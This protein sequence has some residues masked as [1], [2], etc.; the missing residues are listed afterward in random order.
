MTLK[1]S[2]SIWLIAIIVV[3]AIFAVYLPS[4]LLLP[5][6]SSSSPGCNSTTINHV[7]NPDRLTVH[8]SCQTVTGTVERIL[9]EVDGDT[10]IRLRV[11]SQYQG[12]LND[13]NYQHQAGTL[14]LEIVCAY[15][16][17]ITQQDAVSAC[18]GY[19]NP[20]PIPS[21]GEHVSVVGQ[22]VTDEDHGWNE[23]HPV[24]SITIL[25]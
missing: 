8:N 15:P 17:S 13:Y 6:R 12:L 22:Y 10:H 9:E 3:V 7:Y 24:Y 11:D 21:N 18:Q 19:T 16:G 5:N 4:S 23:I 25:S 1:S 2:L 20:V 14:V